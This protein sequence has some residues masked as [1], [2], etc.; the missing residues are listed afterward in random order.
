MQF[1]RQV[2]A[3]NELVSP[4][5]GAVVVYADAGERD[6]EARLEGNDHDYH[7]CLMDREIRARTMIAALFPLV[8]PGTYTLTCGHAG[9]KET[10]TVTAGRVLQV[11]WR[12]R[13]RVARPSW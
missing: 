3:A 7:S 2:G 12:G 13:E 9:W 8:P 6:D 1:A 5:T 4:T 11:D 10:V